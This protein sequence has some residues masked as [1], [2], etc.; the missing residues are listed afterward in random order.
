[1]TFLNDL[2]TIPQWLEYS[3]AGIIIVYTMYLV[4][5]ILARAGLSPAWSLLL[6]VPFVQII[7]VWWFAFMKWPLEDY[8]KPEKE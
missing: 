2:F 6:L 3:L 4:G 5:K 7:A 1:M 8:I